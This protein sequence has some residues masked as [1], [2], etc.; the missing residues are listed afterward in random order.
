MTMPSRMT[1]EINGVRMSKLKHDRIRALEAQLH[2][3]NEVERMGAEDIA[4][5]LCQSATNVR[6]WLQI[7]GVRLHTRNNRYIFRHDTSGWKKKILPVYK[8]NG[9]N[10]TKTADD[11]GMDRSTVYRWLANNGHLHPSR[12]RNEMDIS[13]Y[14]FQS[15]R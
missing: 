6:K 11:L 13:D 3:F 15:Y 7:L 14:K 5:R 2:Q 4:A 12:K 9:W 1:H 8:A 10:A